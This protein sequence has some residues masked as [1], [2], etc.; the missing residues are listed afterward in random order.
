[1]HASNADEFEPNGRKI[2]YHNFPWHAKAKNG[3]TPFTDLLESLD[4]EYLRDFGIYHET[5]NM[6]TK[7][8]TVISY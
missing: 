5:R 3:M 1:M 4:G 6:F 2:G 8:G 7:E